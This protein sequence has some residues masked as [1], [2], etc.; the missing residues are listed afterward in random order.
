MGLH[1]WVKKHDMYWS[2]WQNGECSLLSGSK[3]H[4]SIDSPR[5]PSESAHLCKW[6]KAVDAFFEVRQQESSNKPRTNCKGLEEDCFIIKGLCI[7]YT[8]CLQDSEA[9]RLRP[10]VTGERGKPEQ[11]VLPQLLSFAILLGS[12]MDVD[13]FMADRAVG[14]L[15]ADLLWPGYN[16]SKSLWEAPQSP[17]LD[18]FSTSERSLANM[19]LKSFGPSLESFF[20]VLG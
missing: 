14:H 17:P 20:L 4:K 12:L 6:F 16:T 19:R 1:W 11:P 8:A 15:S 2:I 18:Y 13:I 7:D 9:G 10:W 5:K 3:H